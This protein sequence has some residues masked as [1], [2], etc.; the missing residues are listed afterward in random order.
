MNSFCSCSGAEIAESLKAHLAACQAFQ[1]L[2]EVL[3]THPSKDS[4]RPTK[5]ASLV[6][7]LLEAT[8]V[9]VGK[10]GVIAALLSTPTAFDSLLTL[11]KVHTLTQ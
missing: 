7:D 1:E 2:S 4:E 6:R 3:Q 5:A 9:D 11:M 10:R 8:A